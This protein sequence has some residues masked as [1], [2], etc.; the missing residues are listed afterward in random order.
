MCGSQTY[1]V[2]KTYTLKGEAKLCKHGYHAS[3]R[4]DDVFEYCPDLEEI[5][6]VTIGGST[7]VGHDKICGTVM[8]VERQLAPVEVVTMVENKVEALHYAADNGHGECVEILISACDPKT[9]GSYALRVAATHGHTKCVEI[10][11]PVSDPTACE[12][13]ALRAAALR[14]FVEI[15]GMLIPVSDPRAGGSLALREAAKYGHRK[16]L[17]LL[18]PVSDPAVVAEL[19]LA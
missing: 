14:G 7:D 19:G 16:C 8:T 1:E 15:V 12:S 18:I 11:I 6:E 4:I 13:N 2:G 9:W 3:R 10:L 17:E 5:Y